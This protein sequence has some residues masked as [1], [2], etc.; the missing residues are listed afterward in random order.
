MIKRILT[1]AVALA[2]LGSAAFAKGTVTFDKTRYGVSAGGSV[3]VG[4]TLPAEGKLDVAASDGWKIEVNPAGGRRGTITVT[5][6][7]PATAP[8]LKATVTYPGGEQQVVRLNVMVADPYTS[9]TRPT[10][11]LVPFGGLRDNVT[12]LEDYQKVA[13]AGF[14]MI[15]IEGG[16]C[17]DM[18]G[19][20]RLS[21]DDLHETIKYK[22]GLAKQVGLKYNVHHPRLQSTLDLLKGDTSLVTVHVFDEPGLWLIPE[23]RRR[24]EFIKNTLPD[25]PVHFNLHPESSERALGTDYYADYVEKMVDSLQMEILSYDQYPVLENAPVMNDWYKG[26][27]INSRIAREHNIPLWTFL[28]SCYIDQE[29][30]NRQKPSMANLRLQGYTDLAYGTD[31]LQYFVYSAY[32]G[33]SWAPIMRDGTYTTAYDLLVEFNSELHKRGFVFAGGKV[34]KTRFAHLAPWGCHPLLESDLPAQIASIDS[35]LPALVSFVENGANRYVVVVNTS[36]ESKCNLKVDF[37]DLVYTIDRTGAFAE[38]RSGAKDFVLDE[39]D[40]LVIKYE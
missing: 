1:T 23:L 5:A 34:T 31:V 4:Y 38:Q 20:G 7:D 26:L 13:D 10:V 40:M 21:D 17:M 27:E 29:S 25:V 19:D 28:A 12:S 15:T 33:T 32:G 16:D 18:D 11:K 2:L 36:C 8:D 9:A 14:N 3:T 22:I 37:S 6:P 30:L 35:D 39:G 24:K